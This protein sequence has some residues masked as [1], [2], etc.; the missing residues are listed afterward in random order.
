M[1]AKASLRE[2]EGRRSI[3]AQALRRTSE[4]VVNAGF[5]DVA[6]DRIARP[7]ESH[8]VPSR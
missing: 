2:I 3:G 1:I 8:G 4:D 5:V 7:R 6:S